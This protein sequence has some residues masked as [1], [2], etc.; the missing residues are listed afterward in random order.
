MKLLILIACLLF[1]TGSA[2]AETTGTILTRTETMEMPS[3]GAD[4]ECPMD[5]E[6]K[7]GIT[8]CKPSLE[9]RISSLRERVA[10]L[11]TAL[12]KIKCK[13]DVILEHEYGI[14]QEP[15]PKGERN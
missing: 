2:G 7:D 15:P 10:A 4:V 12:D 3:A 8:V 9:S 5:C 13:L 14:D 1:L 6:K 11:E